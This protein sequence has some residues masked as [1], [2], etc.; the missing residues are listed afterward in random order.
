MARESRATERNV[1]TIVEI[2]MAATG[3]TREDLARLLDCSVSTIGGRMTGAT[4]FT[5]DDLGQLA[6]HF[7]VDPGIF[8]RPAKELFSADKLTRPTVG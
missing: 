5:I 1:R 7:E 8:F 3:T 4:R 6:R 2:L